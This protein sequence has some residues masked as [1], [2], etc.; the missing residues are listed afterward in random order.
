MIDAEKATHD[1][2]RMAE[3]LGVSRSG[4][5][6]GQPARREASSGRGPRGVRT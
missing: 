3:L 1:V 4:Y 2:S 6:P 5:Y